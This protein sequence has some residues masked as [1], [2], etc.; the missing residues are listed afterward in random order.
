MLRVLLTTA[1]LAFGVLSLIAGAPVAH[2]DHP[3]RGSMLP[4]AVA[5]AELDAMNAERS[6]LNLPTLI[7]SIDVQ[8]VAIARV[9]ALSDLGLLSH[10]NPVEHDAVTLLQQA[11]I[12]FNWFGENIGRS[13]L[14][15]ADAP[16][17]LHA[18]WMESPAHRANI[19]DPDFR[20]VGMSFLDDGNAIYAAVVFLD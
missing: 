20:R 7:L 5:L 10:T 18:A 15:A 6:V 17:T 11:G 14:P 19:L 9:A 16:A 8:D 12:P 3:T 2:A 1:L 13:D 4:E